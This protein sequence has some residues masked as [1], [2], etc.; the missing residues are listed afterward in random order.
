MVIEWLK[1]EVPIAQQAQYLLCD[2][3]IWTAFLS[4]CPGFVKKEVYIDPTH[5]THIILMIYWRDRTFW[6]AIPAETLAAIDQ[7]FTETMGQTFPFI[8]TAE[9]WQVH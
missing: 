2:A 8:E 3:A 7:Q 6:K 9:L 4:T 1:V 5:P